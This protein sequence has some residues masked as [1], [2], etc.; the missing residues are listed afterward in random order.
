MTTTA[1]SVGARCRSTAREQG[2][3]PALLVLRSALAPGEL[4][5]GPDGHA[6]APAQIVADRGEALRA[7]ELPGGCVLVV[8]AN[9]TLVPPEWS[10][11][12]VWLRFG[13]SE[14]LLDSCLAYLG[15]RR[16]GES[17]LLQQQLVQGTLAEALTEH[18][19]IGAELA[20]G[21]DARA[22]HLHQK[23]TQVDRT[24]LRLL[25][26]SSFLLGGPGEVADISELLACAYAGSEDQT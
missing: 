26:A 8:H 20:A 12:L 13:L 19:E 10:I 2:V 17:S 11:S 23:I 6:V 22:E 1:V 25:G 7:A 5:C 24:L 3:A 15:A 21:Q 4:P 9:G 16:S 18:L 14:A